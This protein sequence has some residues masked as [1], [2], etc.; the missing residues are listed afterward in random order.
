M[1]DYEAS[2]IDQLAIHRVGNQTND[3]ELNLSKTVVDLSDEYLDGLL[4]KYFFKPFSIPEFYNFTFSDGSFDLNP[5]YNYAKSIFENQNALHIES[6]KIA[7]HLFQVASHPKIKGGD[8]FVV[9]F[10]DVSFQGAAIDVIGIFKSETM[11]SF[12]QVKGA[13]NNLE[14]DY[15]KGINIEKVD[16]GCLIFNDNQEEGYKVCIIDKSNKAN[17]AL[18]WKDLFLNLKP[19]NDAYHSTKEFL[20]ITKNFITK[21]VSQEFDIEKA[22]KIDMLNKSVEYFKNN[23]SFDQEEFETDV[24]VDNGVI[25]SFRSFDN[26]YRDEHEIEIDD[27]FSISNQAVKKQERL[28][29]SVLKLD[30]NF[31]IYIHGD[32][33]KIE[34]GFEVD[35]R[36]FYKIYYDDEI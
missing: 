5:I 30:K 35:G 4:M 27:S 34:K 13:K 11:H 32:R 15:Q 16:K 9:K 26:N 28:F 1:I 2:K 31:H 14:V 12:L 7:K 17:D 20:T 18:Y 24:L 33:K 3:D 29:K 22:D 19:C 25:E 23:S 36:K 21:Q 8:L 10:S 6:V